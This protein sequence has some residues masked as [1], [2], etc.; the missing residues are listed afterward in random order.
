MKYK[1][2]LSKKQNEF[3]HIVVKCHNND[4]IGFRLLDDEIDMLLKILIRPSSRYDDTE[5][6][7]LNK[8]RVNQDYFVSSLKKEV[9]E[10]YNQKELAHI[11]GNYAITCLKGYDG[12]FND[13]FKGIS[14]DWK[15][16]ANR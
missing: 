16:I 10:T 11:A 8:L 4:N 6:I 13:W 3:L 12:T 7:F 15:T 14:K 1:H 5:Q 9:N 2:T